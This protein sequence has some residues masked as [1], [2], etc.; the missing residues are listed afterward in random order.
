MSAKTNK[1]VTEVVNSLKKLPAP[2]K[3]TGSFWDFMKSQLSEEGTWNK[4]HLSVIENE[5]DKQLTKLDKTELRDLW[6]KTD[7]GFEK[8][9][10]D[11]KVD[12]SEMKEDLTDELMGEVMDRMDDHYGSRDSFYSESTYYEE[13]SKKNEDGAEFEDD[14]EPDKVEDEELNLE[15]DEFFDDDFEEEDDTNF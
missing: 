15:D 5:I 11:K 10:S 9:D 13:S 14:S 1:I 12:T 4:S 2:G 7:V 8:S 6:L 3:K